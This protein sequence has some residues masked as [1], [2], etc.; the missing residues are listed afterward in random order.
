MEGSPLL[1]SVV[2]HIGALFCHQLPD[3]SPQF[4]GTIFPL[5]FRCAGLYLSLAVT[6]GWLAVT[7]GFRRRLPELRY[8]LGISMLT[9]PLMV[10]GLANAIGLW[11]SPGLV[12][13]LTGAGV[14]LVLPL[15][16]VPLAQCQAPAPAP[17]LQATLKTPLRILPP[18]VISVALLWLLAHP[19]QSWIFHWLA[20][21]ASA[22]PLVFWST[23]VLAGWR[24][25][26]LF[27][28]EL[29]ICSARRSLLGS[30]GCRR[31][32]IDGAHLH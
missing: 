11:S 28:S 15:L 10:D 25:R 13:A 9:V 21:A 2:W 27:G 30:D 23:L 4:D 12:R 31:S 24:N 7:G 1:A 5:C 17:V 22:A 29:R 14:G 32:A 16:L 26:A 6:F 8:A 3:R 18:A 20:A 19:M